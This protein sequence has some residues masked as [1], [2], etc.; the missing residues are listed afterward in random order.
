MHQDALFMH[1]DQPLKDNY[2]VYCAKFRKCIKVNFPVLKKQN[3]THLKKRKII[4]IS[5][6]CI[7][8]WS[9]VKAV[10][11][12]YALLIASINYMGMN[13]RRTDIPVAQ[14]S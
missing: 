2:Q 9:L 5:P 8:I 4:D 3:H 10:P 12:G 13:R 11:P 7:G 14:S 6:P 1:T